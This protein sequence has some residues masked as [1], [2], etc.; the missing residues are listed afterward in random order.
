MKLPYILNPFYRFMRVHTPEPIK[1]TVR[2]LY[3][4]ANKYATYGRT[5]IFT[6]LDIE[7][8]SKCNLKCSY[9]PISTESRG[10]EYMSEELFGKILDDL[11]CFPYSGRISPHFYGEPTLDERLVGLMRMAREK[12]PKAQLIIHTNGI[13]LDRSK[14]RQLVEAGVSGFLITR[15]T[16]KWPKNVIDIQE[17]ELDAAKYLRLHDFEDATLFNRGGTVKPK[18]TRT[19]NRC[20][21]LSDE[22]AIT[23]TG[24][25]VCTNDFH[26][27]ESFG[28]VKDSHLLKDIWWGDHFTAIRKEL[29]SGTFRLEVCKVCSGRLKAKE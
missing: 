2:G 24:E 28:N 5:D 10:D 27:T 15:H 1:P 21:Y 16:P 29:Q 7:I 20:F 12:L 4:M 23:H 9:C 11:S 22:I 13:K 6:A 14:Y 19:L 17:K 18:K 25:V 3:N 26:I 8:N